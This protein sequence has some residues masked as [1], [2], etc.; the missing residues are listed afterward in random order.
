MTKQPHFTVEYCAM[1]KKSLEKKGRKWEIY[2]KL[3]N[4][5]KLL[6]S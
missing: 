2:A 6:I 3:K 5:K 4:M 1:K